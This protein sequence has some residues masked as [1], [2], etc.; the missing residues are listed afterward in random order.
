MVGGWLT[1]R[2]YRFTP[3]KI[4]GIYSIGSWVGPRAR[5][6]GWGKSHPHRRF[7]PLIVYTV[8]SRYTSKPLLNCHIQP[9]S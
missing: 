2:L 7:E 9:W 3:G 8:A 6:D 1:P 4:P 5:P